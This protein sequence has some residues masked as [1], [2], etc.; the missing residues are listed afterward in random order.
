MQ[1]TTYFCLVPRL[2]MRGAIS[3]LPRPLLA[4]RGTVLQLYNFMRYSLRVTLRSAVRITVVHR[5][6]TRWA[7][8]CGGCGTRLC[9]FGTSIPN[10]PTV[11]AADLI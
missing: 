10:G 1:L 2:K 9:L 5:T 8:F 6:T 7:F 3:F 11:R 4:C